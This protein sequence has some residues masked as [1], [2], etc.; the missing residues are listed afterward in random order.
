[1]TTTAQV[2]EALMPLVARH[3]DLVLIGRFLIVKPV[4]HIL[5]GVF[6]DR[7][8]DKRSFEP[9]IVTYPLVPAQKDIMLGW[10][11]VWLFD[12]SVGMWDVTKP[13]TVTA[14]RNHIE[15]IALPRLRAMK[16]FDDYIAHE[17]S[18][19]TTFDG[20]F[21]DRVFTNIFV[22]AALGDFSKALQLRPQD[23]RI[24]P[25]FTKVAPDFFP[26]LEASDREFIAKTLHQWEEATVKAHKMEHIWE[27]TPFPLEL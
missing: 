21:D 27:P 20:H 18:K 13:D 23:T 17:R 26:A 15:G 12:Q 3:S 5:R 7:S 1:M 19:S 11:P 14:M 8:S 10:N 24:E 9:H 22:A 2:N 4:H 16:T 25:Y 6:V